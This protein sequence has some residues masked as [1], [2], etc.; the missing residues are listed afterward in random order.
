VYRLGAVRG[1]P[2]DLRRHGWQQACWLLKF[3]T[4]TAWLDHLTSDRYLSRQGFE[5]RHGAIFRGAQFHALGYA[6][7]LVWH[8]PA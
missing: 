4:S 3:R 2:A 1:F 7:A 8:N 6:H 5:Q